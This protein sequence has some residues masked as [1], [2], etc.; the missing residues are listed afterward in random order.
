MTARRGREVPWEQIE[1]D[2]ADRNAR[3]P[4]AP[5]DFGA[6]EGP[7][8]SSKIRWAVTEDGGRMPVEL[9]PDPD[10]RL[11]R[12]MVAPGDW[13]IRVLRKGEDPGPEVTRWTSHYAVCP[14]AE[15]FRT[16]GRTRGADVPERHPGRRHLR[17]VPD[18][19]HSS[20]P[21]VPAGREDQ[22]APPL[23][24]QDPPPTCPDCGR[25]AAAMLPLA[26]PVH[27]P[28]G[29]GY[30]LDGDQVLVDRTHPTGDLVA[31]L[32]DSAD[33]PVWA[34]RRILAGEC[35]LIAANRRQSHHCIRYTHRC[36]IC[37]GPARI[38][39]CGPRCDQDAP[40]AIRAATSQRHDTKK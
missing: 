23:D 18:P 3:A 34:V 36:A 1:R 7:T 19:Q 8:C 22:L 37:G 35:H 20:P 25:P 6:C 16:R 11:I 28:A 26:V 40:G 29:A 5:R 17:A 14:D 10:G 2:R 21:N 30:A 27:G 15:W 39:P 9:D 31:A 33:G 13:R 32:V 4:G 24:V 38:Y 12:V